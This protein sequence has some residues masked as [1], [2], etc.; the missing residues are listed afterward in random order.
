MEN[1]TLYELNQSQDV[2]RL[3]C[4]YTLFKR[5]VNIMTS[6]TVEDEVDFS[7]MKQ[8]LNITIER[9]D[10]LRLRFIK[11]KGQILQ[12]FE[13]DVKFD[14]IPR[15]EFKTKEEQEKFIN[16]TKKKA[17]KYLNGDVIEPYFIKTYDNRYM[18]LF[19]VCHLILDIYGITIV[20]KDLFDV[21][22]ALKNNTPLPPSPTLFENVIKKDLIRKHDKE[23]DAKNHEFFTNLLDSH[24]EPYY[25]GIHG[26]NSKIW[27]KQLSKNKHTMKMFFVK[28]DTEGFAHTIEKPLVDRVLEYCKTNNQT[29]A[30]FLFYLSSICSSKLNNNISNLIPLEL[31]NC[32]GTITEKKCAGTKV[33]SLACY[34]TID[35]EKSFKENFDQ[36]SSNQNTLYKHIGYSDQEF[37]MLLHKVYGASFL[38]TYYSITYS[39][40]PYSLPKGFEFNIYS[41]GK[42]A[43]PAY[44]AQLYNVEDGNI[45]MVYDCQ[46]KIINENDVKDFH[47]KYLNIID[48]VL[49][50]P[51]ILIKDIKI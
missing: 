21:Y 8:A 1:K 23:Y 34:T 32:R 51:N 11:K 24:E 50:N 20:F 29:P 30:N 10:C 42:C 37:Q 5:V 45:L 14:T 13:N 22:Y 26:N 6:M 46:T 40:I 48:Q 43:L 25:A 9:N 12:Y 38:E 28:N 35:Q 18:V 49:N 36:F 4:K 44:V 33:Q 39:F 19:K 47:E 15:Y 31:C 7:L 16:K 41:N 17:I 3:Q 2:V 27:Q